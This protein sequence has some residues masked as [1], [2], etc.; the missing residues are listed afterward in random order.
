[1][2]IGQSGSAHREYYLQE[3]TGKYKLQET[4]EERDFG[5]MVMRNLHS[6]V[7]SSKAATKARS[8]LGMVKRNFRRLD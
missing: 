1:M 3:G 8:L 4:T 5:V 2:C 7:Q 6:R